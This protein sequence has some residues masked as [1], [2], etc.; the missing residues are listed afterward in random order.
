MGT[1]KCHGTFCGADTSH[2]AFFAF[3]AQQK[4]QYYNSVDSLHGQ[5]KEQ[6]K[7]MSDGNIQT[8]PQA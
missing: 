2:V 4:S 5:M 1:F 6:T 7:G 8:Q 3:L